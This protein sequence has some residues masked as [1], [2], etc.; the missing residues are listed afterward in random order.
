MLGKFLTDKIELEPVGRGAS[1][2]TLPG[3]AVH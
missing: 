3:G 2:P 1:A